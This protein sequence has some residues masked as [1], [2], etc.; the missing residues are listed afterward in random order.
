MQYFPPWQ[1]IGNGASKLCGLGGIN[2]FSRENLRTAIL[3]KRIRPKF[4]HTQEC[5][6]EGIELSSKSW[7]SEEKKSGGW[8][9]KE[10]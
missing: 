3:N 7:L 8:V 6:L 5:L 10:T 9:N 1:R 2:C 4:I